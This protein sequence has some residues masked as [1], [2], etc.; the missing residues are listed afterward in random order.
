MPNGV[1]YLIF[2]DSSISYI[3][4]VWLVIIMFCRMSKL[5][6]NSV[7]PDQTPS[8]AAS[9][10]GLNYLPMSLLWGARLKWVNISSRKKDTHKKNNNNKIK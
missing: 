10:L 5:N 2:S 4:G 7:D 3:R 8:Y 6:A 9:E 1:F